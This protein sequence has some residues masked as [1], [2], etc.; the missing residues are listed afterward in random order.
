M[1]QVLKIVLS[2]E[3]LETVNG[4]NRPDLSISDFSPGHRIIANSTIEFKWTDNIK[5]RIG[6]FYEGAEGSPFSYVY[7]GSGLLSDT[8]SFSALIYVPRN[9]AEAQL[10]DNGD[11]Q[12]SAAMGCY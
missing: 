7:N 2:G 12:L 5:T 11:L 3:I 10:I 1:Q 8:G 9:E 6:L 4:S